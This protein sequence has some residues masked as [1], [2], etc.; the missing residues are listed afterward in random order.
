MKNKKYTLTHDDIN[1]DD[2]I[3]LRSKTNHRTKR[4]YKP[5]IINNNYEFNKTKIRY[6]KPTMNKFVDRKSNS[7]KNKKR[8]NTISKIMKKIK[9]Q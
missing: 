9:Q 7:E 3:V 6:Y 1:I 4:I 5:S 8:T 2:L